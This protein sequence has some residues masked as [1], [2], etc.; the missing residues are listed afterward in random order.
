MDVSEAAL[1]LDY[2][3]YLLDSCVSQG[4]K[5]SLLT[6]MWNYLECVLKQPFLSG[7]FKD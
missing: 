7:N 6:K 2:T 3:P 1:M 5:I 4:F